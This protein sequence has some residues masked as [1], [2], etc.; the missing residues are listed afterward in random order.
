VERRGRVLFVTF[1][2]PE[3]RNAMTYDMYER[4]YTLCDEIDGDPDVR[5]AVFTGAGDRAFV[6]GTDIAEFENLHSAEDALGYERRMDRVFT[7]LEAVK[8]P[9]LAAIR[10]AC[11]GGGAGI[12]ATCDM[13]IAGPSARF[14]F[15]VARTLGNCLSLANYAR[16]E[17]LIGPGAVKQMV[18]TAQLFDARRMYE[19]GF[20]NE[21][22]TSDDAVLERTTEV[23]ELIASNAP[24]TIAATKEALRR[25]ARG[26]VTGGDDLILG[27][28]TS[29]DFREGM[30]AFF[31][32]RPAN[33]RGK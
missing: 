9:I 21:V 5:C 4:L 2:R 1:N 22:T 18:F 25:T 19:L 13:R 10:G 24:L 33:W 26:Q 27:C 3:A 7:R 29:E 11:T 12:A 30:R 20:L 16:L 31:E 6:A 14:G 23:A 8:V 32:K 28:Y 15:P 17:R